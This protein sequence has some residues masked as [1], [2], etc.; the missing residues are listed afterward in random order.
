MWGS[1]VLVTQLSAPAS[2][3][4]LDQSLDWRVLAF[5]AAVTRLTALLFGTAP[6]LRAARAAPIDALKGAGRT[7][8]S[9]SGLRASSGLVIAQIALSL[10]LVFAAGLF[11]RTFQRLASVPLGF[12]SDRVLAG[13]RRYGARDDRSGGPDVVLP[14]A[15]RCG[16]RGS[17]RGARGRLDVDA[18]R[19]RAPERRHGARRAVACRIRAHGAR[20]LS[21]RRAGSRPTAQPSATA[22]TSTQRDTANAPAVVVVNDA[23]ARR[24][25]PGRRAIGETVDARTVVG[26]VGRSGG[27][28]RLQG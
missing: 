2:R 20:G 23:F 28:G 25:F 18:R 14:P 13:R 21:S 9:T 16:R 12:D 26:V 6:A 19:R 24:I 8:A 10:V 3:M 5:T 4:A 15:R 22:A 11:I 1:R 17:R 27:A 7:G